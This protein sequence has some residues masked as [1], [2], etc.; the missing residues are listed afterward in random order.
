MQAG[1]ESSTG[2]APQSTGPGGGATDT[3]P[4]PA[5]GSSKARGISSVAARCRRT[6]LAAECTLVAAGED[7]DQRVV[8]EVLALRQLGIHAVG[9]D[10]S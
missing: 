10:L 2:S 3:D 5:S 1:S 7:S 8:E 4:V 9:E 6:G